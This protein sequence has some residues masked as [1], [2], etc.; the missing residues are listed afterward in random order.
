ML[1]LPFLQR[2]CFLNELLYHKVLL[3][4]ACGGSVIVVIGQHMTLMWV[5]TDITQVR[6]P[7]RSESEYSR[8]NI[9][10]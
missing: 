3:L 4:A 9:S 2:P 1:F 8:E 6:T 7:K 10:V 5:V